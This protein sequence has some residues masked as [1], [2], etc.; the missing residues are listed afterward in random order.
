VL[1]LRRPRL[2][3]FGSQGALAKE[4]LGAFIKHHVSAKK[5]LC[6]GQ[7][8]THSLL[9]TNQSFL[10]ATFAPYLETQQVFPVGIPDYPAPHRGGIPRPRVNS[11]RA[12]AAHPREPRPPAGP[13][14]LCEPQRFR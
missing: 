4:L 6:S 14:Q 3:H 11:R 1:K 13:V 8:R 12:R 7:E 10:A 5:L 2:L 9:E